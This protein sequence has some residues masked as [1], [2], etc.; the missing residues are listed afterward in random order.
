MIPL[1]QA[2]RLF[3]ARGVRSTIVTTVHNALTFQA[4]IDHDIERG[5][6]ITVHTINFPASE[7]ELP[8]GI[9]NLSSC[10]NE[11]MISKIYRSTALLPTHTPIAQLIR[12]VARSRLHL[13]GHVDNMELNIPRLVFYPNNFIYHAVSHSLKVHASLISSEFL[14]FVVPD[15]PDNITMKRSQL[16]HHFVSKTEMGDWMERVQQSK[17]RSYGIAHNTFYEIEPAYADH[18]KKIKGT[19]VFSR[20]NNLVLEKHSC[21]TWLD[22]Q[23]PN[24]VIYVCFGSM[25]RFPEA[26]ITEIAFGWKEGNKGIGGLPEGF[27]ERIGM[28]NKGWAPRLE[29]LQH[30]SLGGFLTR[31]GWNSVLETAAAGVP[32]ITWPLYADH[33]YNEKLMELL[34]IGV[35]IGADV[36]NPSF[37]I[38]S[39]VIRKQAILE[40]IELLTSQSIIADRIRQNSKDLAIKAKKVVEEDGSLNHL[41]ALIDEL[42]AIKLSS[43][44]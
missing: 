43:K 12:D 34:G 21:L 22:D 16:S 9:E 31:C 10:T 42:K 26:Q 23:K 27:D 5:Y 38:T 44:A 40:A 8:I 20:N 6:P 35:G 2:A 41:N 33:F 19:K 13:L 37:V 36:W 32:L 17:K 25:V 24:S 30:P 28:K 18:V 1:V 29:I 4:S 39:P 11:E 7:V 15:L 14:S 3:A